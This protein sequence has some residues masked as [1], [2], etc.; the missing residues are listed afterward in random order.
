MPYVTAIER[1]ALEKGRTEGIQEGRREGEVS[2]LHEGIELA[3]ELKSGADGLALMPL[4]REVERLDLLR[5]IRQTL[6]TAE[7]LESVRTLLRQ[8]N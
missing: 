7:T 5:T 1:M 3:L 8:T 4:V 6:R 2:G